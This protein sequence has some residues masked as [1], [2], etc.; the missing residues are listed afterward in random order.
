MTTKEI[1]TV[2]GVLLLILMFAFVGLDRVGRPSARL[3]W[4]GRHGWAR[5]WPMQRK[6][7][8]N[9][10]ARGSDRHAIPFRDGQFHVVSPECPCAP[11]DAPLELLDHTIGQLYTHHHTKISTRQ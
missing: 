7:N 8:W 1:L 5:L 9:L 10:Y 4:W 11:G 3:P 6:F 2:T